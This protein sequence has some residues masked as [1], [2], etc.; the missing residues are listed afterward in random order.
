MKKRICS[1]IMFVA[2]IF[3]MLPSMTSYA[4]ED[5]AQTIEADGTQTTE[6]ET[7][8][9]FMLSVD[10]GSL[11]S[12]N[13]EIWE[14]LDEEDKH[15]ANVEVDKNGGS[16]SLPD[17]VYNIEFKKSD[18]EK[19]AGYIIDAPQIIVANGEVNE[20]KDEPIVI[21]LILSTVQIAVTD[22][23]GQS[24]SGAKLQLLDDEGTTVA[25]WESGEEI[26]EIK[27]LKV[28]IYYTL[29][30]SMVPEGYIIPDDVTF[31]LDGNSTEP[32][33]ETVICQKIDVYYIPLK[34]IT[35]TYGEPWQGIIDMEN[36]TLNG[37]PYYNQHIGQAFYV[38]FDDENGKT[39]DIRDVPVIPVGTYTVRA[40]EFPLE[41]GEQLISKY[42]F[43]APVT[44]TVAPKTLTPD[45]FTVTAEEKL[46]DGTTD[47]KLKVTIK[48]EGSDEVT[49]VISGKFADSEV[50]E[51]KTITYT[52]T[53]LEGKDAGNYTL[54]EGGISG[55]LTNG[56]I[57]GYDNSPKTGDNSNLWLGLVT[58]LVSGM[59]LMGI[60]FN[61][62]ERRI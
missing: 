4:E 41:E 31:Y 43:N 42:T 23:D 3:F 9:S 22:V 11:E 59:A 48:I 18:A 26:Y 54:P 36:I 33:A 7:T 19:Y 37:E 55:T 2:M 62:Y 5:V 10:E 50:G 44:V 53:A 46:Y 1:I 34:S 29:S 20:N 30:T 56:V 27:G 61:G 6:T 49:A 51:N 13:F 38:I 28:D 21:N 17:G 40:M 57:K 24:L 60:V 32:H 39:L 12:A 16:V 45:M 58:L 15:V 47:V 14:V 8:V 52:I 35:Y 25:E